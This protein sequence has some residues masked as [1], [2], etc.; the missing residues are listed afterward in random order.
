MKNGFMISGAVLA[1]V[2]IT[3]FIVALAVAKFDFTKLGAAEYETNTYTANGEFDDI[4]I[5]TKSTDIVFKLSENGKFSAV[6]EEM[7]K[8]KHSVLVEDGT[9]KIVAEDK[10]GWIDHISFFSKHLTMTVYLPTAALGSLKIDC[11]TGDVLIP[12]AFTFAD[13][14]IEVSTGNV[15][16]KA[17]ECGSMKIKT[18]TGD[19]K[20]EGVRAEKIDL[21][22]ST[23]K[24]T[25]NS[26]NC[27]G[28]LTAKVSTGKIT[29]TDVNCKSFA[30]DGSTGDITLKSVVAEEL[31]N[32]KRTTGDVR[33][34]GSDAA[35][36]IVNTSTGD[37]TGAL[38]TDKVFTANTST[39]RKS[40]PLGNTGGK[41]TITTTT[42][43]IDIK[44][45]DN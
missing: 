6:C 29:F 32:I 17:P 1:A 16:C 20:L 21:S 26:I 38:R 13:V 45:A 5:N 42:G 37:V 44:I 8:A 10:R 43:K 40:V 35:E 22:V 39:G 28:A 36:I 12:E 3:I 34:E 4:Y 31:M 41:C 7:S 27:R 30:S 11:G 33:F 19:I 14:D 18:S 25:G 24:I 9:L 2:G 15:T 23:G